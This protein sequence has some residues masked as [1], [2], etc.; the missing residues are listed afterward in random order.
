MS[1]C[2]HKDKLQELIPPFSPLFHHTHLHLIHYTHTNENNH[3]HIHRISLQKAVRP[4][5][6]PTPSIPCLILTVVICCAADSSA[7]STPAAARASAASLVSSNLCSSAAM[8][9]ALASARTRGSATA[10][11]LN[12]ALAAATQRCSRTAGRKSHC[13]LIQSVHTLQHMPPIT[14]HFPVK[15]GIRSW[16]RCDTALCITRNGSVQLL[17]CHTQP[18][19][20]CSSNSASGSAGVPSMLNSSL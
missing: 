1:V 5:Q 15:E 3:C 18:P 14:P 9:P 4:S 13:I 7:A 8:R 11:D 10:M 12:V 20:R 6:L 17:C 16:M 19:T 2:V